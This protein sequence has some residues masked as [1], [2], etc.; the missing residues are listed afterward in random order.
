MRKERLMKIRQKRENIINFYAEPLDVNR[1]TQTSFANIVK[2]A[3]PK[4]VQV[5]QNNNP[6]GD[7]LNLS[8]ELFGISLPHLLHEVNQFMNIYK[9][10]KRVE[11][12]QS[13][14]LQFLV[15]IMS[16]NDLNP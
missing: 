16:K 5:N 7:F 10:L 8:N 11:D 3:T 13:A 6:F 1:R 14:Y 2:N 4:V 15:E 12:K 9:T